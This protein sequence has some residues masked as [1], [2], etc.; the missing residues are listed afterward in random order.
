MNNGRPIKIF[1]T[2]LRN[3]SL[4]LA[5]ARIPFMQLLSSSSYYEVN[6]LDAIRENLQGLKRLV[7]AIESKRRKNKN[8][9]PGFAKQCAIKNENSCLKLLRQG[10]IKTKPGYD[11]YTK[12]LSEQSSVLERQSV[13]KDNFMGNISLNLGNIDSVNRFKKKIEQLPDFRI[14]KDYLFNIIVESARV[15]ISN[16]ASSIKNLLE[17]CPNEFLRKGIRLLQNGTSERE[18]K[19]ILEAKKRRELFEFEMALDLVKEGILGIKR[20]EQPDHLKEKLKS[21]M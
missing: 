20:G 13:D 12:S 17:D 5:L 3:N 15:A 14:D 2:M 16:G 1:P 18:I 11:E 9:K 19:N 7:Y 6:E 10:E 8:H 21:F 4:K